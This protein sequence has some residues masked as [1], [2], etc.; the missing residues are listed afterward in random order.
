M[1]YKTNLYFLGPS[2]VLPRG[3]MRL[4]HLPQNPFAN[5]IFLQ[6]YP[7]AR[8]G[9]LLSRI[10]RPWS[11]FPISLPPKYALFSFGLS[12]R[13]LLTY[14]RTGGS[15]RRHWPK[16]TRALRQMTQE[17]FLDFCSD[18]MEEMYRRNNDLRDGSAYDLC[19]TISLHWHFQQCF[20]CLHTMICLS[21]ETTRVEN[22]PLLIV[23]TSI[24]FA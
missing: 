9:Q 24:I 2:V 5:A 6:W 15:V 11:L 13:R 21:D 18:V 20:S 12:I 22:L 1:L 10:R 4:D 16:L 8:L 19:A 3:F 17:G 14:K 23:I 7:R